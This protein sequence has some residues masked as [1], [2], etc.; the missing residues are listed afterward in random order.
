MNFQIFKLGLEK[1]EKPEIKLSGSNGPLKKQEF[2]KNVYFWFTDYTKAFDCV[3][4][5]KLWKI[6]K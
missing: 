5:K 1:A 3:N 6:L 2:Q 4:H